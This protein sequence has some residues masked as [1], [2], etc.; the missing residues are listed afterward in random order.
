MRDVAEYVALCNTCQRVKTKHQ[1]PAR[2][3]N[4]HKYLCGSR[5][6]LLWISSWDFVGPSLNMISLW[7]IIDRLA[8]VAH[9]IPVKMTYTGPQ[10]VE[11]YNYRIAYF[12]V[13]PMR[14]VSDRETKVISKF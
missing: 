7:A 4:S 3:C 9:F 12:H 10:L 2:C 6:K 14:I 5:K 13:V 11:L 1:R 8:K